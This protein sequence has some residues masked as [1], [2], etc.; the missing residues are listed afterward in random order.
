MKEVR[1]RLLREDDDF[2]H[3]TG[4]LHRA[5]KKWADR[6]LRFLATHQPPEKTRERCAGTRTVLAEL[7]GR[8]VGMVTIS[9]PSQGHGLAWYERPDVTSFHQFAVEPEFQGTGLGNALLAQAEDHARELGVKELSLDTSEQATDLIDYYLR[10]GFRKVGETQ[11]DVVN[12][13][14]VVLSKELT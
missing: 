12:Y 10:K 11:W 8:V 7:D 2:V 1:F 13:R 9:D 3:L 4:L 5:Y 6:G 14:S